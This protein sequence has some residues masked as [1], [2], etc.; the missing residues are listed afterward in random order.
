M[1]PQIDYGPPAYELSD[2]DDTPTDYR[3]TAAASTTA[4]A[5]LTMSACSDCKRT[6]IDVVALLS[7]IL[8]AFV[9]CNVHTFSSA[10]VVDRGVWTQLGD[11][12]L[13]QVS[14]IGVDPTNGHLFI[15]HRGSK[16]WKAE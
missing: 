2:Y 13:G 15:F 14:G 10:G 3:T 5:P 8:R 9:L 1:T 7:P 6:S 4:T 11:I 12:K 16:V